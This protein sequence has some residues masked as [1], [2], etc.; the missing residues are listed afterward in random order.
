[1]SSPLE[2]PNLLVDGYNIIGAWASLDR[3]QNADGLIAAREALIET[4][5]NYSAFRGFY[6]QIVFD[7]YAQAE[8]SHQEQVTRNLVIHY[9]DYG[10]T[11]DSYIEKVCAQ[12]RSSRTRKSRIVVA[13]SDRIQ[14][15]T[16]VGYGAEW[17]S[18]QQL[19][20]DVQFSKL[21]VEQHQQPSK[22]PSSRY[23]MNNLDKSVQEKLRRMRF[24]LQ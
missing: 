10:Q 20:A 6:T 3:V 18:A 14:R 5:T 24:G 21:G 1:M 2:P 22:R 9:T 7:A 8:P 12:F 13:T 15:Q 23:L 17:M 4:L 16:V 11:A 19:E